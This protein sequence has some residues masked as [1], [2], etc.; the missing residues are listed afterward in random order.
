MPNCLALVSR[1]PQAAGAPLVHPYSAPTAIAGTCRTGTRLA[2]TTSGSI[3]AVVAVP[4]AGAS[5]RAAG[6]LVVVGHG[7]VASTGTNG[8]R[9][10]LN[11]TT[12]AW[13]MTGKHAVVYREIAAD[14][15]SSG[16][17][18]V[19][20]QFV[21]LVVNIGRV[22]S[23]VDTNCAS[24]TVAGPVCLEKRIRPVSPLAKAC[25]NVSHTTVTWK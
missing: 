21:T 13:A 24:I 20:C 12:L 19:L 11:D 23:I 22:L 7:S 10:T 5:A 16:S 4:W 17:S 1:V 18:S 8:K 9:H 3:K 2:G 6:C 15:I 25:N 14:H